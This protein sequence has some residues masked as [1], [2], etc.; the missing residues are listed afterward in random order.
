MTNIKSWNLIETKKQHKYFCDLNMKRCQL[1]HPILYHILKLN[2]EMNENELKNWIDNVEN[3][4]GPVEI[5]NNGCFSKEQIKYYFQKYLM[6]KENG[7]FENNDQNEKI[8]WKIDAETVKSNFANSNTIVFETTERCN[9]NCAYCGYG[10]LYHNYQKRE[11]KDLDIRTAKILLDHLVK[12]WN[13]SLNQSHNKNII[14]YFYGGEPL[15]HFPL[16]K[17][18]V[19][20][21]SQLRALHNRFSFSMTTNG[22]LIQRYMDFLYENNFKLFISLDGNE[23]NNSYR[24]FK[25]GKP[26]YNIILNEIYNLQK[27]YPNYFKEQVNFTAVLHN[28]NSVSDAYHFFKKQFDK[29]VLMTDLNTYGIDSSHKKEF[30]NTYVNLTQSLHE[31]EDY[32]VIEKELFFKLPNIKDAWKFL[33]KITDASYDNYN[34]LIYPCKK[35]KKVPTGTCLPFSSKIYL[36][37]QGK[38]LPCE[39]ISHQFSLGNVTPEKIELDYNKIAEKYNSY[40]KKMKKQCSVCNNSEFCG[41]CIFNIP[42]IDDEKNPI[43]N[44]FMNDLDRT[45]YISSYLDYFE[46]KPESFQKLLKG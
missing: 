31:S 40:F 19:E 41:Q 32:S 29:K 45:K 7:Y 22:S 1:C 43:C 21:V 35:R 36:T 16:I 2:R 4:S 5:K 26:T 46:D 30:W 33:H 11:D 34:D 39:N 13:S 23:Q 24:T 25:N 15:M 12:L 28:R 9:M 18:I 37:A 44:G 3:T 14:I 6:L 8:C 38:I 10:N 42:N 17:G 27:K 20:Y